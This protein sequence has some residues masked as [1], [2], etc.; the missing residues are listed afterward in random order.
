M[1]YSYI[2]LKQ[3]VWHMFKL[4][5]PKASRRGAKWQEQCI[6]QR[7]CMDPNP[8]WC[9]LGAPVGKNMAFGMLHGAYM[10]NNL[11]FILGL[12]FFRENIYRGLICNL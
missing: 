9:N 2:R 3:H 1:G 6:G 4:H 11:D 5:H 12:T 8:W 10:S 7:A